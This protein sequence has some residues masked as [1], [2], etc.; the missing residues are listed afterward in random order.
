LGGATSGSLHVA[1]IVA[2]RHVYGLITAAG[3]PVALAKAMSARGSIIT[4]QGVCNWRARGRVPAGHAVVIE[5]I[6]GVSRHVTRP[7]VFGSHP[8]NP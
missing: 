4:A 5:Q 1:S 8:I 3:G 2:E 6:T 7:D